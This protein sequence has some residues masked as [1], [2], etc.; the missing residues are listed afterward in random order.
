MS[1]VLFGN[2]DSSSTD[3]TDCASNE[4]LLQNSGFKRV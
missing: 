4:S 1:A 3:A 2:V